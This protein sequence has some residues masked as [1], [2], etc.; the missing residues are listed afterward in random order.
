MLV[1]K[2]QL[3]KPRS[4]GASVQVGASRQFWRYAG[5]LLDQSP[6]A[7]VRSRC[8]VW[9]TLE[10]VLD[11]PLDQKAQFL[12]ARAADA[13]RAAIQAE[14]ELLAIVRERSAPKPISVHQ[15]PSAV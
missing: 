7:A 14:S 5:T 15:R 8:G 3:R 9:Q 1:S 6:Q 12:A 13:Y 10:A 11:H 4:P 2:Y